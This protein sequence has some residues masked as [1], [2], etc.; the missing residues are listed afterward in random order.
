MRDTIELIIVL[1]ILLV[2]LVLPLCIWLSIR[3]EERVL[4]DVA[5]SMKPGDLYKCEFIPNNPFL[6]PIVTYV[7]IREVR[8]DNIGT[9]WVSYYDATSGFDSTKSE[10]LS[11]FLETYVSANTP[12]VLV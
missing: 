5:E 6:A 2:I 9:P 11:D 12:E 3:K 4:R 7:K 8:Y 1:I 10:K